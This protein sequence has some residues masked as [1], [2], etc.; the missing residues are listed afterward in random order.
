M[1]LALS[2]PMQSSIFCSH[3]TKAEIGVELL[4]SDS[5]ATEANRHLG[6]LEGVIQTLLDRSVRRIAIL[7]DPERV[8]LAL[9]LST[10][11]PFDLQP[12]VMSVIT[13][14]KGML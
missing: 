9:I 2:L 11:E 14:M 4:S 6:S 3:A 12:K 7:F 1:L 10:L 5:R 8:D 13:R